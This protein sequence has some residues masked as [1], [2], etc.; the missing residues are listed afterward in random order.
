V[1]FRDGVEE[2]QDRPERGESR[3][4]GLAERGAAGAEQPLGAGPARDRDDEDEQIPQR[5]ADPLKVVLWI[6]T[7]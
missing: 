6:L 5:E 3:D 1:S 7:V 2:V 4:D